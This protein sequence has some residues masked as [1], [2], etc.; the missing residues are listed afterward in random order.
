M[1]FNEFFFCLFKGPTGCGKTQFTINLIKNR[2]SMIDPPPEKCIF[3][4]S[5]YQPIFDTIKSE[6]VK[7]VEGTEASQL[8][9]EQMAG[10]L[11]VLDDQQQLL[12]E[13][14][15][16]NLFCIWS[17]HYSASV[18]FIIQHLFLK[19]ACMRTLSVNSHYN[20]LFT[21]PKDLVSVRVLNR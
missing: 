20:I 18:I 5:V 10:C 2:E 8:T 15:L 16:T 7:F 17:H 14:Y 9:P 1:N 3:V 13:K 11:V 6:K 12:S 19:K 21:S 4:Y